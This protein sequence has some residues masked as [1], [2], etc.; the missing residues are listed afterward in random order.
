M[1]KSVKLAPDT[2]NLFLGKG[3]LYFDRQDANGSS[4]GELDLGNCTNFNLKLDQTLKEHFTSR[5]GI[6]KRD[7]V[8]TESEKWSGKFVLEEYAKEILNLAI[9]GEAPTY[10]TQSAG[11]TTATKTAFRDRWLDVGYRMISSVVVSHGVTTFTLNTDY[12]VDATTGRVKPLSTGAIYEEESLTI[13]FSYAAIQQPKLVPSQRD[14]IGLLRFV[15]NNEQGPD[16]EVQV[17]KATLKCD[18]DINFISEDWGKLNFSFEVD[19]DEENHPTEPYFRLI[20]QR[21]S[22]V[23]S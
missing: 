4:T 12:V 7:L 2:D 3:A 19:S 16:I 11:S 14:C 15:P 21:T 20:N 22:T 6:K 8:V 13:S 23:L 5:E 10:L 17:W 18:G 9:R 1:S